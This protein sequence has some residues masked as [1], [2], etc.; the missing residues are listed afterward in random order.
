[1][2]TNDYTLIVAHDQRDRAEML[3]CAARHAIGMHWPV[4]GWTDDTTPR[5]DRPVR[6]IPS[7]RYRQTPPAVKRFPGD[8][9][10]MRWA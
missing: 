7:N 4:M 5:T 10:T 9:F 8:S 3:D 6:F 1:M 2:R